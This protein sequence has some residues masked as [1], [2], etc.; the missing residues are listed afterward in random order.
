MDATYRLV[1]VCR[2]FSYLFLPLLYKLHVHKSGDLGRALF[3]NEAKTGNVVAVT[4]L[5]E[6][7]CVVNIESVEAGIALRNAALA[8]HGEVVRHMI[9]AGHKLEAADRRAQELFI[10]VAA[11]GFERTLDVFLEE[12][13]DIDIDATGYRRSTALCAAIIHNQKS[14]ISKLLSLGASTNV[15]DR[16]G[17]TP[18][19]LCITNTCSTHIA[20]L[21]LEAGAN[22]NA[23]TNAGATP[24]HLAVTK[25][26]R[27]MA[28]LLIAR[29]AD[30]N[31]TDAQGETALHVAARRGY[32]PIVGLLLR[33]GADV[34]AVSKIFNCPIHLAICKK[35]FAIVDILLDNNATVDASDAGGNTPLHLAVAK[36]LRP[37]FIKRLVEQAP[38]TSSKKNDLGKSPLHLAIEN[39]NVETANLLVEEGA[40]PNT[41]NNDGASPIRLALHNWA[42]LEKAAGD[43]FAFK[44]LST[45]MERVNV[46]D[47]NAEVREE[48]STVQTTS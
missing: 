39:S 5:L 28:A 24:L 36:R 42:A 23:K 19:H 3:H 47:G 40:D 1:R 35:R 38:T 8:G 6:N 2:R 17:C 14:T 27:T 37:K 43:E 46:S 21:V 15:T 30:I 48:D 16:G 13:E 26:M 33:N 31:A 10:K 34:N 20:K 29:K 25:E 7:K 12:I 9:K 11:K 44:F 4:Q 32:A 22:V 41:V 45:M 18:L